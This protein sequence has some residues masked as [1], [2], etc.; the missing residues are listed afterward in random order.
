MR[1]FDEARAQELAKVDLLE[2]EYWQAWQRSCQDAETETL[3]QRQTT[4]GKVNDFSK[5]TKGQA[6]DKRFLDGVQWCIE[7]RCKILGIDA[8]SKTDLTSG[9]QALQ[10]VLRPSGT[11]MENGD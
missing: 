3:R 8:P 10:I 6:G 11:I 4:D 2:L 1:D 7:R 5:V 9:G